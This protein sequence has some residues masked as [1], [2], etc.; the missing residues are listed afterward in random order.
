LPD[1]YFIIFRHKWL[2]IGLAG[3]GL[4]AAVLILV[5]SPKQYQ[6]E[7]KLYISYVMENKS[8]R[9]LGSETTIEMAGAGG[10]NLINNELEILNSY[11]L[12]SEVAS[13]V[14]P[15]EILGKTIG[16]NDVALAAAAVRLHLKVLAAGRSDCITLTMDYPK[17]AVPQ[18]V[19]K[20]VISCYLRKHAEIHHPLGENDEFLQKEI[21]AWQK[22]LHNIDDELHHKLTEANIISLEESKRDYAGQTT[23]LHQ[24]I[25]DATVELEEH[26][27][28]IN[29]LTVL[30]KARPTTLATTTNRATNSLAGSNAI[31][32]GVAA[33]DSA[34]N[35]A[36]AAGEVPPEKLAQYESLRSDLENFR[37]VEQGL[38]VEFNDKNPRVKAVEDQI[39]DTKKLIAKLETENPGL[40]GVRT[41]QFVQTGPTSVFTADPD[42]DL[43][44][45]LQLEMVEASRTQARIHRLTNLFA[46]VQTAATNLLAVEGPISEL[47][48][49]RY[50]AETNFQN[51][52][53]S[54]EQSRTA[55]KLGPDKINAINN[56]EQPTPPLIKRSKTVTTAVGVF[57]GCLIVSFVLAFAWELYFDRTFKHSKDIEVRLGK[58]VLLTIPWLN[59]NGKSHAVRAGKVAPM[60]PTNGASAQAPVPLGAVPVADA[61]DTAKRETRLL[62]FYETLRDRLISYFE[63]LNLTHKPKLVAICGCHGMEGVTTIAA[64]LATALSETGEGSV[65]LVDMNGQDGKAHHFYNGEIRCGLDEALKKGKHDEAMVQDNLYFVR[66]KP[67]DEKLPRV[68]PKR[69]SHL[70][71]QMKTSDYDYIIF[72]MPSVSQISV[73]PRLA[74]FMDMVLVVIESEKTDRELATRAVAR[75]QESKTNIGLVLNKKRSYV[76]Q[77]LLPEL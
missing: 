14:G 34:T 64:G 45:R 57:M 69:F 40:V 17:P 10:Y 35:N 59:G 70:L 55:E 2:I 48:R 44:N 65:L 62:P 73:T 51:S 9:Q 25:D 4:I 56:F 30:L 31:P 26:V 58:P 7:A 75:L 76:P 12:L 43:R 37:R 74:R 47:Q 13:N 61:A 15:K 77:R 60:L 20:Q 3:L 8:P 33:A 19:L 52:S 49:K 6:S 71:P 16:P 32:A 72:D 38:K 39:A 53:I 36:A 21:D 22:D 50:I 68:L 66:E 1:I 24:D 11:D 5:F 46:Q 29:E 41:P 54:L 63:A 28:T 27:A 42:A 67:L 18:A 23:K